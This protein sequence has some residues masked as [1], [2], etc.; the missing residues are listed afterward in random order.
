M[1]IVKWDPVAVKKMAMDELMAN[2][3]LT[4]V[5]L[6]SEARRRLD[7]ITDPDTPRD[8]NYRYYLSKY[9][10]THTVTKESNAIVID[11]GMKVGPRG[12]GASHHGFYIEIGSESAAAHPYLR[13]AVFDNAD[14]IVGLLAGE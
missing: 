4:G 1:S 3:E 8:K 5:F 7:A 14:E 11:V 2:A 10:L 13:P 6:E 12:S 9:L